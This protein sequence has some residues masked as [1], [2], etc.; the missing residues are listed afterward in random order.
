[1]KAFQKILIFVSTFVAAHFLILWS[2][3]TS[4]TLVESLTAPS[5]G[6]VAGLLI[7]AVGVFLGSLGNLYAVLKSTTKPNHVQ[8]SNLNDLL[9]HISLTGKEVKE[10]VFFV[11]AVLA[12]TLLLPI[13]GVSDIPGI[14]WPFQISWLSKPIV[15]T[16]LNLW[17]TVL[18]FIA[19]FD[20]VGAMFLL[21]HH[22]ETA[23]KEWINS[24]ES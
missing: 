23:I 13:I 1:M 12:A 17:L 8:L 6:V 14:T 15:F 20:C 4:K 16:T 5:L 24:P 7:G 10:N 21:H 11:L 19:I 18:A 22:Y 2:Y 9:D 3:P